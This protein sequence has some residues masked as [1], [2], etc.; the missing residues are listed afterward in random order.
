VL[1]KI[2]VLVDG[3]AAEVKRVEDKYLVAALRLKTK[4]LELNW[5]IYLMLYLTWNQTETTC[6]LSKHPIIKFYQLLPIELN[7]V[8][9][10]D[11]I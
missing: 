1:S 6:T 8:P 5:R 7:T 9:P 3:V 10:G 4:E 11:I 2:F